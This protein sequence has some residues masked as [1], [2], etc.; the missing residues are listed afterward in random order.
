MVVVVVAAA[1]SRGHARHTRTAT[2]LRVLRRGGGGG[3]GGGV[4]VAG[5]PRG[6][7]HA[8]SRASRSAPRHQCGNVPSCGALFTRP[9]HSR[10]PRYWQDL[11]I[12]VDADQRHGDTPY[13]AVPAP[14]IS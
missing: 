2:A 9:T 7:K 1:A 11:S 6:N 14:A 12:D 13:G 5:S 8:G 10:V 4:C 3:G